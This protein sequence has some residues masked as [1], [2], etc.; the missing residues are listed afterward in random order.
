MTR[1]AP[2]T[3]LAFIVST[4]AAS[5]LVPVT[6]R[7]ADAAPPVVESASADSSA[8]EAPLLSFD[9]ALELARRNNRD[10]DA[11][12]ARLEQSGANLAQAW[13]SLYPTITAQ[14][15][16]TH[17][18]REIVFQAPGAMGEPA[19]TVIIQKQEQLDA[20]ANAVLPILVPAAYAGLKAV[21][22]SDRAAG[23]NFQ[24]TQAAVLE[25]AAQAYWGLSGAEEVLMARRSAIEVA[26][27]T[28]NNATS[29]F[30]AGTAT[31]VDVSRAEL[32]LLRA[33]QAARESE[34]G[35]AQARRAL[36][37]L[38][39]INR[40]FRVAPP[41]DSSAE[42]TPPPLPTLVDQA[43]RLRP[44]ITAL[45]QSAES[46]DAQARANAWRWAPSLSAFGLA[47]A[48][49]YTNFA[50]D[51]TAW[52]VGAQLD[53]A[54]YDG[55]TRDAQRRLALAQRRETEVR[56]DLLRANVSDQLANAREQVDVKR[57]A[58]STAARSVGLARETLEL[59]RAQY[60][61]GTA[62]QLDLLSA[63][64][65]LVGTQVTLAQAHVDAALSDVALRR[66]AGLFPGK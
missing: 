23:S 4:T 51:H 62:T 36:I 21:R 13:S 56:L 55:G 46:Y 59:V 50:G 17:N 38:T 43:L 14:G 64:D 9:D 26:R 12:R 49:N 66:A 25:L 2:L 40:P 3:S 54:L 63:Q 33:E 42:P 39:Q 32:A 37:T 15:K 35:V 11:A 57:N 53:W 61:A 10:I 1:P 34:A 52:A 8:A 22:L 48:F 44:E 47:R 29:R 20:T 41:P 31:K 28:K 27:Q 24:A 18:N 60:E 5:A 30:Q 58:E 6:G 65:A 19:R 45:Q 7:A 16:Y